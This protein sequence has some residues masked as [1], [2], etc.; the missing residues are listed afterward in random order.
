MYLLV[1]PIICSINFNYSSVRYFLICSFVC[2]YVY[3]RLLI[4]PIHVA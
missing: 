3:G 2:I 4:V 1:G